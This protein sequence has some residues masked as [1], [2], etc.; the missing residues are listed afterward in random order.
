MNR[1]ALIL[2]F[3]L[4]LAATAAFARGE[5]LPPLQAA[6][7]PAI[8]RPAAPSPTTPQ[9]SAS[10]AKAPPKRG[11]TLADLRAQVPLN[12]K[13]QFQMEVPAILNTSTDLDV[14]ELLAGK[15]I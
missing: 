7:P 6:P 4:S 10:A 5:P 14:Q 9:A 11:F 2:R 1:H 8:I 12:E 15:T 13:G 3:T